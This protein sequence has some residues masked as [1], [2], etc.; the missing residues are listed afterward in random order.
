MTDSS[1]LTALRPDRAVLVVIDVQTAFR[2]V[3]EDFARI[4]ARS[5]RMVQGARALG[6]PILVTEQYPDGL[7]TTV[8]EIADV[9]PDDAPR[10]P[11]TV[12]SATR[13]PGFH[14]S[15]RDQVLLVGIEA[16]VCVQATA[17]DLRRQGLLVHVAT[18][19]VGSRTAEDR[20][21]GLGRVSAAGAVLGTTESMLLEL[22]G[23]ARSP[24][25]KT[26]QE[27]IR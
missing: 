11:K 26:I 13:A 17:L 2:P 25:F 1:A 23:D 15:G 22:L 4:A 7:G 9:L 6:I 16:H 8:P 21:A 14:L 18:D 12:F 24:Q 19:A 10:L 27:L 5:A 3:I 20:A